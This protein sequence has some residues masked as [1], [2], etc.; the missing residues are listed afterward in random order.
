M[1]FLETE[2]SDSIGNKHEIKEF[3]NRV[4]GTCIKKTIYVLQKEIIVFVETHSVVIAN[5][6]SQDEAAEQLIQKLKRFYYKATHNREIG[7]VIATSDGLDT[8]GLKVTNPQ[9]DLKL[10]Y[11]EDLLPMHEKIMRS[12]RTK[13]KSGIYLLYGCPGTGKST[14]IRHL[15]RSI[16]KK[17]LFIPPSLAQNFDAPSLSKLLIENANSVFVIEDAEQ[18]L[19]SRTQERNS[20]IS[21]LLNLTDGLLVE[22]LGIQFIATFNTEISSI[23]KA[24]RRKGR[25]IA[26]YEFKPLELKR[27]HALLNKLGHPSSNVK[28]PLTLAEIFNFNEDD[29]PDEQRTRIGLVTSS[30]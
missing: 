4:R 17:V 11:N 15:I 13:N 8:H 9:I 30:N 29:F 14:Y 23:D 25:L 7:I 6:S 21:M 3:N 22:S 18:L 24:L 19:T 10:N 1:K 28:K 16:K 20:S 2:F 27:T 5:S 26:Q 12:L